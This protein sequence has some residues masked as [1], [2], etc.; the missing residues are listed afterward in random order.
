MTVAGIAACVVMTRPCG[1]K[2]HDG[3]MDVTLLYFD[4][5]PH[6]RLADARLRE[7]LDHL[8]S[9]DVPVHVTVWTAEEAEHR[10]FRGSPTIL[11]AGRDPFANDTDPVGLSCRLYRTEAGLEYAPSVAQLER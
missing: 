9:A 3:R 7:A 6:W 11:V 2:V 4:D 10:R 5:C 8:G 1:G